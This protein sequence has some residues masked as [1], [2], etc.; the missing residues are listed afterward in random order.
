MQEGK[1]DRSRALM[2]DDRPQLKTKSIAN[3]GACFIQQKRNGAPSAISPVGH[4]ASSLRDDHEATHDPLMLGKTPTAVYDSAQKMGHVSPEMLDHPLTNLHL[5][6]SPTLCAT[7]NLGFTQLG[8][9]R[10]M[11]TTPRIPRGC[12]AVPNWNGDILICDPRS[13]LEVS[14]RVLVYRQGDLRVR[15]VGTYAPRS[16]QVHT[17]TLRVLIDRA[18]GAAQYQE[19]DSDSVN[20]TRIVYVHRIEAPRAAAHTKTRSERGK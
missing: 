13:K 11:S 17:R 2:N 6:C 1:L 7:I 10:K 19:F 18:A 5:F 15:V 9:G 14:C 4:G 16:G 8:A 12:F 20:V 3:A